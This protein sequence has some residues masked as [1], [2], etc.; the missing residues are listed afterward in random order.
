MCVRASRHADEERQ[1]VDREREQH[2]AEEAEADDVEDDAEC[3]HGGSSRD[4]NDKGCAFH[5]LHGAV[6]R[7][8]EFARNDSN[9]SAP[10]PC[11]VATCVSQARE[12]LRLKR[13]RS[14]AALSEFPD[15]NAEPA[16]LVG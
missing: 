11:F 16:R 9:G 2:P 14:R 5:H 15:R 10:S 1:R 6:G 3:E 13:R 4:N 7:I 8:A 12:S